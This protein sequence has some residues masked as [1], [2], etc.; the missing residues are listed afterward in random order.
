MQ[1]NQRLLGKREELIHMKM[2]V[3][4]TSSNTT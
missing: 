1:G 3:R 2:I 4:N